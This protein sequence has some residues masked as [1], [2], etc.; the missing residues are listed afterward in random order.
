M[1]LNLCQ[2]RSRLFHDALVK[3]SIPSPPTGL[4]DEG[5]LTPILSLAYEIRLLAVKQRTRA[6]MP[7]NIV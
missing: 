2:F 1:H 3:L 5:N 7:L 4:A 6:E